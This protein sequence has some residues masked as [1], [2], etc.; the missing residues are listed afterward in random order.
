MGKTT[1]DPPQFAMSVTDS[2][3][4]EMSNSMYIFRVEL[5]HFMQVALF[6]VM[7]M[8]TLVVTA[9]FVPDVDSKRADNDLTDVYGYL[10]VSC[11]SF[12]FTPGRQV[13]AILYIFSAM[14]GTFYYGLSAAHASEMANDL[15]VPSIGKKWATFRW[16]SFVV[17]SVFAVLF[18]VAFLFN[19]NEDI[20]RGFSLIQ[21][22]LLHGLPNALFHIFSV[23][24]NEHER[25]Y[26]WIS[27]SRDLGERVLPYH[28]HFG[29]WT[30]PVLFCY[31]TGFTVSI[32]LISINNTL[33]VTDTLHLVYDREDATHRNISRFTGLM[34]GFS[35][36]IL[37][38]MISL[39]MVN[40]AKQPDLICRTSTS[41]E[42]SGLIAE[43]Q[44]KES[45]SEDVK[46]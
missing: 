19:P 16:R 14:V 38:P 7:L 24:V 5:W 3:A 18:T 30:K 32:L 8:A 41:L 37:S 43:G 42:A 2:Q 27:L 9:L 11:F 6:V 35:T 29:R 36:L 15:S 13:G 22:R 21:L 4:K 33:Y 12:D 1:R 17:K 28:E 44:S 46:M 34:A 45:Q 25:L 26:Y 31:L 10:I 40:K 23:L 39:H 20:G